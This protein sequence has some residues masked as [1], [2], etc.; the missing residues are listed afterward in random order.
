MTVELSSGTLASIVS[1][2]VAI[3]ILFRRPRRPL[4]IL[5]AIVSVAVFFW[6]AAS[7]TSSFGLP[8]VLVD[9]IRR[10]TALLIPPTASLFFN[11]LLRDQTMSRRN[12]TP[13]YFVLS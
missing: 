13:I 2:T 5:F 7:V 1:M 10:A 6:H 8:W 11:E 4:Y 9:S 3:A 12:Y